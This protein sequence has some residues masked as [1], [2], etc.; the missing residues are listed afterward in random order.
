M[1]SARPPKQSRGPRNPMG[2]RIFAPGGPRPALDIE[3]GEHIANTHADPGALDPSLASTTCFSRPIIY[4]WRTSR[5]LEGGGT[6]CTFFT[7]ETRPARALKD[8]PP[9]SRPDGPAAAKR[10]ARCKPFDR[11]LTVAKPAATGARGLHRWRLQVLAWAAT[12]RAPGAHSG[13]R[14]PAASAQGAP[15][16]PGAHP[17]RHVFAHDVPA[18]PALLSA[19]PAGHRRISTPSRALAGHINARRSAAHAPRH[20]RCMGAFRQRGEARHRA[21]AQARR[22]ARRC[23]SDD[24]RGDCSWRLRPRTRRRSCRYI[25][26]TGDDGLVCDH[27]R[28]RTRAGPPMLHAQRE[29]PRCL[30]APPHG[31]QPAVA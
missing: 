21:F 5:R 15:R 28:H 22:R 17:L 12:P 27:R 26:R 16:Y 14:S 2:P 6:D 11:R 7:Q 24:R 25:I 29:I 8:T 1:A 9:T 31:Q 30:A 20:A 19:P 18:G 23:R 13:P 4:P 3:E 10:R